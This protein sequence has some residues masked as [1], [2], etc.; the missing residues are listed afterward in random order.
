MASPALPSP[1]LRFGPFE[2]DAV[3][4]ELRKAGTILKLHPQPQ[5]LLLLLLEKPGQLVTRE[6]IQHCLWGSN[7]FVDFEGG[8]NFCVKQIRVALAD[9]VEKPRYI[10]TVPRRGYRF[11]APVISA[12][13]KP[14]A[15][16][17]V[18]EV[19][20]SHE[21]HIVPPPVPTRRLARLRDHMAIAAL[22][23]AAA[24]TIL[25]AAAFWHFSHTP[26]LSEKDTVV[27]ADFRNDTS[28][29]VFD[30]SLREAL[31]TELGQSPFLN[32]LSD[33]KTGETLRLMGR[34]SNERV[35]VNVGQEL[36]VR[37]GS[38][39]LL[40]GSISS[41]G[42]HYL[43][44]LSAIACGSGDTLAKEAV[45]A[46]RK[47]DVLHSL[48]RAAT[49]LRTKLG[50]SLPSVQ[51][52]DV[53][54]EAT[55][56]SLEA[57]QNLSR[58]SKLTFE[59][60]DAPGIPFLKRAI[61]LDPKFAMAYATLAR[62]YNNLNQ[63]S[64]SLVF[65]AKAY[66][67]RDHVTE[68]EKLNISAAYFRS[69][70]DL[71]KMAQ[72]LEQ[73]KAE[74]PRDAG[75]HGSLGANASLLG[76]HD[77][78]LA[79]DVEALRLK[80]DI[81]GNYAN[82][83]VAYRALNHPEQAQAVLQQALDRKLDGGDIRDELYFLAFLK[84]DSLQMAEQ[85]AWGMGKP[86][87]EA[88]LLSYQA[89]TEAYFGHLERARE[90]SRRAAAAAVRSES[91]EQAALCQV[92]AALREAEFGQAAEARRGIAI[93]LSLAAGRDVKVLA[94]LTLARVG[95]TARAQSLAAKLLQ[96]NPSNTLLKIYW[97]PIVRAA[98]ALKGN[99][100][101]QAL[102]ELQVAAP[103]ELGRSSSL[104]R[105]TL[106]PAYLRGQAYLLMHNGAAAALEFQKAL[107][108]RGLVV[109]LVTGCLAQLQIARASA[110]A[111][112]LARARAAYS[113]FL[114]LWNSADPGIPILQQ[115]RT[116]YARLQ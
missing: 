51:K 90:F 99:D 20:S 6:E 13:S 45:E 112:D 109:N 26:K 46:T 22:A 3:N 43:V 5:R 98:V 35:T 92:L 87:Q 65:A 62:H 24:L 66:E 104:D 76:Q 58:A 70:G 38:K 55:T 113:D 59:R 31:A 105:G 101:S 50:E 37:T 4:G 10:E 63:P 84:R 19:D 89:D 110:L 28:D 41:L 56:T 88:P 15:P 96:E 48:S 115:A 12:D 93:A 21:I 16:R 114:S 103:Y 69:T 71:E 49:Q 2:L 29:P 78:A 54:I 30:D 27:L 74:Y 44:D 94:A 102:K 67:L 18:P 72:V 83:S 9:N 86:N 34:S 53:P 1:V 7:T 60:G 116:E 17:E 23:T 40:S 14:V 75:P 39:A 77:K 47:E 100:A 97:L 106:Y 42:S 25:S 73:W 11:I 8:I 85:V 82:L 36:C 108:H 57:L 68:R 91:Q 33:R 61:E 81:V 80:P 111:G 32:V 95:E 107:D 79:E 64:L 52:F